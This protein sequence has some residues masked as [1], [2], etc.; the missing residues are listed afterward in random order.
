MDDMNAILPA[1]NRL[2][3]EIFDKQQL[4]N[5]ETVIAVEQYDALPI[6]RK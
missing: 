2:A 4:S 5:A 6:P 1:A 3:N